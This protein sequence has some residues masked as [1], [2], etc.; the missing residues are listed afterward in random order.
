MAHLNDPFTQNRRN[1]WQNLDFENIAWESEGKKLIFE[2]KCGP[3]LGWSDFGSLHCSYWK[4]IWLVWLGEGGTEQVAKKDCE[5][6]GW[7]ND[8]PS[9]CVA[10]GGRW[11]R[12]GYR[13]NRAFSCHFVLSRGNIMIHFWLC[14]VDMALRF[15][16]VWPPLGLKPLPWR[17][18]HVL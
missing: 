7:N 1:I 11:K 16:L 4:I 12:P 9:A 18:Y 6:K 5:I 14:K 3:R 13:L 2:G 8:Q 17:P 10:V 15:W